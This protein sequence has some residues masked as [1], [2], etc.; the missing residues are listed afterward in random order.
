MHSKEQAG[1]GMAGLETRLLLVI[2]AVTCGTGCLR[3]LQ[4]HQPFAVCTGEKNTATNIDDA[5]RCLL[6]ST[7]KPTSTAEIKLKAKKHQAR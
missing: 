3:A 2:V 4:G 7:A 1:G 6:L 5:V